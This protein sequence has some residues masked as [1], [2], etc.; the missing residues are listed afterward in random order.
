MKR[1]RRRRG[2]R[3]TLPTPYSD[4]GRRCGELNVA[5]GKEEE[6]EEEEEAANRDTNAREAMS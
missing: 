6:E 1:R 5:E 2:G 4:G 3:Q